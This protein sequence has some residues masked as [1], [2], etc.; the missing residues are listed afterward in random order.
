M[1]NTAIK[2]IIKNKS[3]IRENRR[4]KRIIFSM[5][6]LF[7]YMVIMGCSDT[8]KNNQII[9]YRCVN[10][11]KSQTYSSWFKGIGFVAIKV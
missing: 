5:E 1:Q 8:N 11:I 4:K 3:K 6:V 7:Y 2:I 10:A 9:K